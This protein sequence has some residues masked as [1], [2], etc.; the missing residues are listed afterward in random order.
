MKKKFIRN[1]HRWLG[2]I[3]S[4]SILMSSG[5]GV[6]HNVM[7]YTQ[8][9]PPPVRPSGE[10][11][12]VEKIAVPVAEVPA[13]LGWSEVQAINV[14]SI[15]AEPWYQAFATTVEKPGYV[16]AVDGRVDPTQ[17]ERYAAQIASG[18][19][20]G[21][22]VRKTDYLT[23]FNGEYINIFRVLPVYRFDVDDELRTRVYVSTVTGSVTRHTD[24]KR[25]FEA[26]IFTNFHKLGFI[27]N[28][29][30]RDLILSTLTLGAFLVSILGI[31]LFC[32]TSPMFAS[33]SA[34]NIKLE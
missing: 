11:M 6:L 20:G 31:I 13:R 8:K 17:D 7:T 32:V 22:A 34:R 5:S 2:L 25:Q 16:N 28:K 9:P 27:P 19:V 21:A 29:L 4:L 3:F 12:S 15:A 14:R 26:S 18:F 10:G 24:D 23:E 33:R 1:A 30:A